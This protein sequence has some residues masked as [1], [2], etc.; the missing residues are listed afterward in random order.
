MPFKAVPTQLL[1]KI[2]QRARKEKEEGAHRPTLALHTSLISPPTMQV[3]VCGCGSDGMHVHAT[4][5]LGAI[6]GHAGMG[7]WHAPMG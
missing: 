2:D 3:L 1:L 5:Q 7:M 6:G 4:V